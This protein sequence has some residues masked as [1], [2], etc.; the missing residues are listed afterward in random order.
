[1][2][3]TLDALKEKFFVDRDPETVDEKLAYATAIL[4]IYA[5]PGNWRINTDRHHGPTR[6]KEAIVLYTG[7]VVPG[8]AFAEEVLERLNKDEPKVGRLSQRDQNR[9]FVALD[10]EK[11]APVKCP[12]VGMSPTRPGVLPLERLQAPYRQTYTSGGNCKCFIAPIIAPIIMK[13]KKRTFEIDG[14][15]LTNPTAKIREVNVP[16]GG[17]LEACFDIGRTKQSTNSKPTR[18]SSPSFATGGA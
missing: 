8:Y 1:M 13:T 9:N 11:L 18:R 3:P 16:P 6:M 2:Q 7:N 10:L 12:L 4:E 5:D 15:Y 14:D 17:A